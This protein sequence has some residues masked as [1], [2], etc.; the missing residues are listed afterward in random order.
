MKATLI[1]AASAW[2]DRLARNLSPGGP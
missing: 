2:V 1:L